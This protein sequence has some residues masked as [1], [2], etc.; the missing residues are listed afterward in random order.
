[1]RADPAASPPAPCTPP[2]R[3]AARLLVALLI[4]LVAFPASTADE[5]EP[6]PEDPRASSD[7]ADSQLV[8]ATVLSEL[9]ST[10]EAVRGRMEAAA[11][12]EEADRAYDELA[13]ALARGEARLREAMTIHA[14]PAAIDAIA[15]ELVELNALRIEVLQATSEEKRE[16]ILGLTR[17][18][19]D[20]LVHEIR[21]LALMVEWY[22]GS[23]LRQMQELPRWLHDVSAVGSVGWTVLRMLVATLLAIWVQR[24][25]RHW[26]QAL[27]QWLLDGPRNRLRLGAVRALGHVAALGTEIVVL[28]WLLTLRDMA[29]EETPAE[30]FLVADVAI[31][32]GWYR[33]CRAIVYRVIASAAIRTT[34]LGAELRQRVLR[35][36]DLV[37]RYVLGVSIF[38]I[39]SSQILGRGYLHT[40]VVDFAWIGALPIGIA[41]VRS[42][43]TEIDRAW[44][45][46]HPNGT[47]TAWLQRTAGSWRG[48]IPTVAAVSYVVVRGLGSWLRER[49]LRFDQIRSAMAWLFRRRLERSAGTVGRGAQEVKALP[50]ALQEAFREDPVEPGPLAIDHWPA[51][52][53][54]L[55][56]ARQ[57]AI[58]E[59][60]GAVAL[61]GDCG[62]GKT[63]WLHALGA[64]VADALAP[65]GGEKRLVVSLH[66][67]TERLT[68]R[69]ELHRALAEAL[70]V[71]G[72]DEESLAAA[73][74]D[75][76][77]RLVLLDCCEHLIL[78][79][80]GGYAAAEALFRL[81]SRTGP[82]V[83]W[84]C[85]FGR[86]AWGLIR[87][88]RL[89]GGIFREVVQL[90]PWTEEQIGEA[91]QRRMKA[92]GCVAIWDDLLEER[93]DGGTLETEVLR[94]SERYR[95]LLWIHSG[96]N[97][98]VALHF[99]LRSLVPDRGNHV[100]VRLFDAPSDAALDHLDDDERFLLAAVVL[101]GTLTAEEA[102]RT[103]REPLADCQVRLAL[104]E[105]EG[106][107]GVEKGR[108]AVTTRWYREVL[109]Q[110]R[111][112][113]LLAA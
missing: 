77:R 73:L 89:S 22:P 58:G 9:Q 45:A 47:L 97:P 53:E 75:G 34:E 55:A 5:E 7:A 110:L 113:H 29:G 105:R 63:S 71:D 82:T 38:L 68:T 92:A 98:R 18:G 51:Q 79:C 27:R 36:I 41:L 40:V 11:S 108:Y 104:L 43:Q 15:H 100:R 88:M 46:A 103:L 3:R 37:G 4:C 50:A 62:G 102:A 19:I 6:S 60:G 26:F 83:L 48:M 57:L 74:L 78:R 66:T 10:R 107:L 65:S 28:A 21:H 59:D 86:H 93:L 33:L 84:V 20:Q 95:R 64:K 13:D 80:V 96:G 1:M 76:P 112:K 23:R 109:R 85:S 32:W 2:L 35:S 39:L 81:T 101:H 111:R 12:P 17:E 61:V 106:W 70:G 25:H 16:R 99:W 24:R 14:D 69:D 72:T 87:S 90:P 8:F 44:I 67:F 49:A 91:I 54:I 30:L 52:R 94:T 42:W 56:L 31:A